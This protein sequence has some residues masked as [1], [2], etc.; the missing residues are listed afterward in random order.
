MRGYVDRAIV[1]AL[2]SRR[3]RDIEP[4]EIAARRSRLSRPRR[5][6]GEGPGRRPAGGRAL[7]GAFKGLFGYAVANGWI[8]LSPAAQ[9]TAAMVG[10][11]LAARTRVLSD[12]EIRWVMTLDVP[13]ARCCASCW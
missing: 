13:R 1:P 8:K 5:Q 9:L 2:G 7:L 6:D 3:V 4:S 11:P 12:D 10:A